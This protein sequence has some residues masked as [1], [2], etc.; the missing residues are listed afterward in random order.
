M[1]N[2]KETVIVDW[3]FPAR[4]YLEDTEWLVPPIESFDPGILGAK[5]GAKPVEDERRRVK[6]EKKE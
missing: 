3:P 1:S 6:G 2:K 5:S 4:Y